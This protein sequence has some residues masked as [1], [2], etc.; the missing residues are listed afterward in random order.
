M[1]TVLQDYVR[2]TCAMLIR[3][4]FFA[5][6]GKHD[7]QLCVW[8]DRAL[9]NMTNF[10]SLS[11]CTTRDHV[12]RS[13]SVNSDRYDL[14]LYF[15]SDKVAALVDSPAL[16]THGHHVALAMC[17]GCCLHLEMQCFQKYCVAKLLA[18]LA[19]EDDQLI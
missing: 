8:T 19:Q 15:C 2:Y 9:G 3:L 18:F 12:I 5:A 13:A 4:R 14:S 11:F 17:I 10:P 1:L 7:Y 16:H 6:F